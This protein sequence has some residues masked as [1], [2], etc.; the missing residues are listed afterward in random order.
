MFLSLS[1]CLSLSLSHYISLSHTISLS[2]HYLSLLLIL[3]PSH[4]LLSI[5]LSLSL[6]LWFS[7]F[8]F[9][10]SVLTL[11]SRIKSPCPKC[12]ILD[13]FPIPLPL[14]SKILHEYVSTKYTLCTSFFLIIYLFLLYVYIYYWKRSWGKRAQTLEKINKILKIYKRYECIFIY[15]YLPNSRT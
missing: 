7:L 15:I 14:H 8:L 3:S 1:L 10:Y 2:H 9:I 12:E 6:S 5:S 11:L 4:Y 13:S